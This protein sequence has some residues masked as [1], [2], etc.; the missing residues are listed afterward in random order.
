MI[1]LFYL[2]QSQC[3]KIK[4][5]KRIGCVSYAVKSDLVFNLIT[6]SM[7]EGGREVSTSGFIVR[8]QHQTHQ[9]NSGSGGCNG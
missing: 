7:K 4:T 6:V 2:S 3:N 5:R 9:V 1:L 8:S